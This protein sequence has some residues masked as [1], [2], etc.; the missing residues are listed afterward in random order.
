MTNA[1]QSLH[2]FEKAGLGKAPFRYLG[3]SHEVGPITLEN[4]MMVGTPGQPM[5]SCD[6]C[7][8]GI[9]NVCNVQSADGNKFKVGCDCVEKVYKQY[10]RESADPIKRAI[11]RDRKAHN[12]KVRHDREKRQLAEFESWSE[13]PDVKEWLAATK[14]TH[15]DQTLADRVEWFS[16]CAGTAGNLKLYRE[17]KRI[18]EAKE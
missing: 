16:R 3:M 12:R 5:G 13:T 6:Y 18:F 14:D 4:G 11:E 17:L 15:R 2:P 8:Q 7:G 9:A 1:T 10:G